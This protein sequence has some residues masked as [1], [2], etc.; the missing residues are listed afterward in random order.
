MALTANEQTALRLVLADAADTGKLSIPTAFD[1]SVD[2]RLY[3]KS[4]V[5]AARNT[6]QTQ[7]DGLPALNTQ[8][9]NQLSILDGLLAKFP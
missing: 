5:Q 9:T 4:L 3:I 8:Y 2:T 1:P 7:K 6:I